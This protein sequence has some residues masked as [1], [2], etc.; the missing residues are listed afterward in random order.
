MH[1][2]HS[3]ASCQPQMQVA[4]AHWR[5]CPCSQRRSDRRRLIGQTDDDEDGGD[6]AE[7]RQRRRS[8]VV[9]DAAGCDDGAARRTNQANTHSPVCRRGVIVPVSPLRV[10]LLCPRPMSRC[11]R[12]EKQKRPTVTI[13]AKPFRA[14]PCSSQGRGGLLAFASV[15]PTSEENESNRSDTSETVC[16]LGDGGRQQKDVRREPGQSKGN[17]NEARRHTLGQRTPVATPAPERDRSGWKRHER[18]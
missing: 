12:K 11:Q 16:E 17:R 8:A 14:R 13:R 9:A 6:G 10:S 5:V 3:T 7:G 4:R 18:A 15:R 2:P 1:A